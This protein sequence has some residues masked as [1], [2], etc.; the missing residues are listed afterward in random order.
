MPMHTRAAVLAAALSVATLAPCSAP[1]KAPEVAA[2]K[3]ADASDEA[4]A[5]E[6]AGAAK[7]AGA[8]AKAAPP[9]FLAASEL[10]PHPSS[11]WTAGPVT[12]GFPT[13]L[14]YCLGEGVPAYD[15]QHRVF[16]TDLDTGAA[17]V[18]VVAGS[19]AKGE[20]LATLLNK[21]I[22][23]CADRIERDHPDT[24]AQGRNYGSLPVEEGAQVH[25]LCAPRRPT[26]PRTSICCP[27][28]GTAGR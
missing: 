10:P 11:D 2:S 14:A 9:A 17:Q 25:G 15:Y 12:G 19:D 27:W 5:P 13:E 24:E 28:G 18:V 21:E 8:P 22:G 4:G 7:E 1:L 3:K 20:A 6:E 26:A 23:S 16:R